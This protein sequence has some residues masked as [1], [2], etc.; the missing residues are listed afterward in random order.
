M[1]VPFCDLGRESRELAR[2]LNEAAARVIASG[3]FLFGA[4]LEAFEHEIAAWHGLKH[5]VG[6]A[7]GTDGVELALR[8]TRGGRTGPVL[9][10]AF[11]PPPCINAIEAAGEK[12]EL[13][14][15]DPVTRMAK[16]TDIAVHM[17]GMGMRAGWADVEDCAHSMGATV[18][19][20]MVGTFAKCAAVSFYPSKTM[21]AIGD[22]GVVMTD[23]DGIAETLRKLRHYGFNEDRTDIHLRGQNSRLSE[24]QAAMLR[25]KLPL[26]HGWIDRRREIAARYS[27]ELAGKVALPVEPEGV[28]SV[29][30]CYVVEHPERDRLQR[31]L[32]TR[33]VST[34][35]H[36]SKALHQYARWSSL[37]GDGGFPVSERLAATVL[38]LPCYPYLTEQEQDEVIQAV[39]DV[40]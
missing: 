25:V 35:V 16:G 18:D 32:N 37:A 19:G 31:D 12:I 10:S 34:Q 36:Y 7:S 9:L 17:F 38:S 39:K 29:W 27:A 8:A 6:V 2:E 23:D 13:C 20:K 40:T 15:A 22:G 4:E 21:G 30:H 26:V 1:N 28:R 14:D 33:G 5:A 11:A 3:R 24:M